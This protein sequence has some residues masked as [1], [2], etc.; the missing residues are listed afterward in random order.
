[1]MMKECYLWLELLIMPK[2]WILKKAIFDTNTQQL[3]D[4]TKYIKIKNRVMFRKWER[5]IFKINDL[6]H[7]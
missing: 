2:L 5:F 6:Q 7:F 4:F 1:M 3:H